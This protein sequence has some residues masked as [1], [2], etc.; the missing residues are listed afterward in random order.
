MAGEL[1]E[2]FPKQLGQF[3]SLK[4][5]WVI[6]GVFLVFFSFSQLLFQALEL[7][8]N[9]QKSKKKKKEIKILNGV[10]FSSR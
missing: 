1:S 9:S 7:N 8:C 3:E 2:A 5:F 6:G 10:L 4:E